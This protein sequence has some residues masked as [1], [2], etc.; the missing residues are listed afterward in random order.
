GLVLP[1][2][3]VMAGDEKGLRDGRP[4]R[5]LPDEDQGWLY[6]EVPAFFRSRDR[7]GPEEPVMSDLVRFVDTQS[8]ARVMTAREDDRCRIITARLR[9]FTQGDR[10]HVFDRPS[11]FRVGR[12]P[13]AIGLRAFAMSYAADL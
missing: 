4:I 7:S 11:T 9:R 8:A 6:S 2:L 1:V 13:V 12:T 3:S 10:A 5:R